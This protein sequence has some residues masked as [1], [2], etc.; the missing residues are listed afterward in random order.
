MLRL[1]DA[2]KELDVSMSF[3]DKYIKNGK[4]EVVWLGGVRRLSDKE[5]NRIKRE[6]VTFDEDKPI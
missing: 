3:L 6:G 4:I 5:M 2:A 1:K